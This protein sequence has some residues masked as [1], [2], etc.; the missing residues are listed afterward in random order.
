MLGFFANL[1]LSPIP[2]LGQLYNQALTAMAGA[3]RVFQLLDAPPDWEDAPTARA[4]PPIKGQV[5]FRNVSFSYLPDRPALRDI[6]FE[7]APGQTVA[8]VGHTGSGKSSIINLLSKF[9]VPTS[10]SV[11]VDGCDLAAVKG[12]SLHRQMS[13]V[14]QNNFLFSGTVMD[15]IRFGRPTATDAE[16]VEAVRALGFL[17]MMGS[18][19]SGLSTRVGERGSGISLGQRQLICFARAMLSDPRILIL[20]EATSA[21]D[22]LTELRIQ[23]A[24][25]RLTAGRTSFMVAHRLS[26]IRN[27]HLV[28]VLEQ[29]RIIE[30]G[31]HT[32]LVA[33]GGT[34]ARMHAQFVANTAPTH[35]S[36]FTEPP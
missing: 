28:L 9:Y 17:D 18:L 19:P 2:A 33:A 30:R 14:S 31:T 12:E 13:I 16:I 35:R 21:V 6:S 32:Q 29:G 15:N 34:Y 36:P 27:A 20:D 22:T 26:T 5:A 10:G 4:L 25:A 11:L 23:Q 7:V 8:L 3:E 24:L 1:F